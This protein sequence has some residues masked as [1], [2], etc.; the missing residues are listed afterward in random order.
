ML[1]QLT[2]NGTYLEINLSLKSKIFVS[3]LL[4]FILISIIIFLSIT[5]LNTLW[6]PMLK[7]QYPINKQQIVSVLIPA[8]N[9]EKNIKKCLTGLLHQDFPNYEII[10]LDDESNDNTFATVQEIQK[11]N[12]KIRLIQGGT[13]P[14]GWIGKNWACHQLSQIAQGNILIFTDADNFHATHAIKN[15]VGWMEHLGIGMFSA[16][17]QQITKTFSE[18]LIV[19]IIDLLLYT[20]LVLWLTY[21]SKFSSLAA[22][23]GQWLAFTREAY[24]KIGGHQAVCKQIVEDVELSRLAKKQGIKI[25]TTA[26]TDVVFARMYTS[27]REVWEGFSKNLFGLVSNKTV[28]FLVIL[29]GLY[30]VYVLPFL[31]VYVSKF[32]IISI[33]AIILILILR[34]IL[35]LRFKHPLLYSLL[36]H[37]I[38][39]F[40][41]ILIGLNSFLKINFGKIVWKDREIIF[42]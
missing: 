21:H 35:S 15:T 22:A 1:N 27:F 40:L 4:Y 28:H 32:Q 31:L 24:K 13:L 10:V 37:P 25:L 20:S 33:M 41:T 11:D 5:L 34:L 2:K 39:I 9:E 26:G 16:F 29:L 18:K 14:A 23:N 3:I 7:K 42:K 17:P 8:R 12:P 6:G 30:F 19:P 38:S 36:F